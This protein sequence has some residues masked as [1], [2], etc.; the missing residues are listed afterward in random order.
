M[1]PH[2]KPS[3]DGLGC[4]PIRHLKVSY[5]IPKIWDVSCD[6]KQLLVFF[7]TGGFNHGRSWMLL[8]IRE[9]DEPTVDGGTCLASCCHVENSCCTLLNT[10]LKPSDMT[11]AHLVVADQ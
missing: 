3:D 8:C 6:M 10:L 4:N 5:V 2:T 1:S 7:A 11:I 9:F